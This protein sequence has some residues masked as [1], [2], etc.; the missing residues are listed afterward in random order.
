VVVSL[1][2]NLILQRSPQGE[3]SLCCRCSPVMRIVEILDGCLAGVEDVC[4][5]D[6][7]EPQEEVIRSCVNIFVHVSDLG[8]ICGSRAMLYLY[9]RSQQQQIHPVDG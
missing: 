4:V 7:G 2:V 9:R 8:R 1:I 6:V 3:K 5:F